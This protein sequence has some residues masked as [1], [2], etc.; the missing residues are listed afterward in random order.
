MPSCGLRHCNPAM[1]RHKAST[2]SRRNTSASQ[3]RHAPIC[4]SD[5][6]NSHTDPGHR[7][8]QRQQPDGIGKLEGHLRMNFCTRLF[9]ASAT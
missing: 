8:R 9:N 2:T 5:F 4:T 7:R 1:A 3:R 6:Q